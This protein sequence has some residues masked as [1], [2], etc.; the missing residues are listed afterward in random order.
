MCVCVR[1]RVR[2]RV[3]ERGREKEKE[4]EGELGNKFKRPGNLQASYR[5]GF[6]YNNYELL[7]FD[8][9][10]ENFKRYRNSNLTARPKLE[11]DTRAHTGS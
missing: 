7:I 10:I 8:E 6:L 1:E 9:S 3:S 5:S 11:H 2:E 4:R